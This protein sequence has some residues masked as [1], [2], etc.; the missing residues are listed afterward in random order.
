MLDATVA[1]AADRSPVAATGLARSRRR[2]FGLASCAALVLVLLLLHGVFLGSVTGPAPQLGDVGGAASPVS[3]R[4]V[5]VGSKTPAELE[6]PVDR[7]ATAEAAEP[8]RNEVPLVPGAPPAML[9]ATRSSREPLSSATRQAIRLPTASARVDPVASAEPTAS[10]SEI[11]AGQG[12]AV[13]AAVAAAVP[14]A[15][16]ATAPAASSATAQLL[17][18]GEPPPPVYQTRLPPPA[19]LRYEVRRGPL[20]GT[21]EIRWR[22]AGDAYRLV[23]EARIAGLTLLT[24]TSEGAID[25]TGLAPVRL[26]DQR[27]RRSAQAANFSR[28]SGKVT[29][30]GPAVERPLLPGTQDRLSWMIQLAGIVA[31]EPALLVDRSQI[32]MVVV[33][34]RG[35]AEVWVLRYAGREAVDTVRATVHAVKFVRD[36]RLAYDTSAEIWL[37]PERDYF[38]VHATLHNSAGGSEYELLLERIEAPP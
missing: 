3:V 25:A 27:A 24:Q 33:G 19:T 2:R 32:A 12:V 34:A 35:E 4:T 26:V 31:A 16:T 9:P 13:A 20:R 18:E 28:D 7:H 14:P 17:A 38:P 37:D 23:L 1:D 21:G 5:A 10:A 36:G 29:F 6:A 30:S 8:V 15:S 22:P 11:A